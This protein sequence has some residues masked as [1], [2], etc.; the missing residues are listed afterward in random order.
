MNLIRQGIIATVSN[1]YGSNRTMN[2]FYKIA[3]LYYL[4]AAPPLRI[5][6]YALRIVFHY[7]LFFTTH[8]KKLWK[9]VSSFFHSFLGFLYKEVMK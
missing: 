1:H 3:A 2:P 8:S 5:T 6:H 4:Y 7:A 9:N